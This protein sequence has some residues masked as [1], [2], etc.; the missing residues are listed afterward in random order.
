MSSRN[1]YGGGNRQNSQLPNRRTANNG[2]RSQYPSQQGQY[3]NQQGQQGQYGNQAAQNGTRQAQ[4]AQQAQYGQQNGQY[5]QQAQYGQQ[6]G[7]YAQ[8][9]QYGQQNGQYAQ[10]ATQTQNTVRPISMPDSRSGAGRHASA[11]A[12]NANA[13]GNSGAYS[14]DN[15]VRVRKK[16]SK[17]RTLK[18]VLLVILI[19][20]LVA[21]AAVAAYG[22][23]YKSTIESNI[24]MDA[25]E[26]QQL[27]E[28]LAPVD[29]NK[30]Q[31][32][33]VL[34]VGS[35]NWETYG[36]RSDAL[37]LVRIDQADHKVTMVSIP[38]DTPYMLNGQKVKINQAFSEQGATGAVKA[39][40]ELTG[41]SISYYAEIEFAGLANFVDQIGGIYVNV[42]YTIDYQ[43]YTNDQAT[44][45]IE[46]GQQR[47]SGEQCVALARM[48]TAYGDDQDA[49]RQ[50]NVRAMTEALLKT[51][52]KSSPAAIPGLIQN[53]TQCFST[54]M[55]LN[56]MVNLALDFAQADNVQIYT[57]TGPYK[58]DIDQ[59][60]GM[61]LCYEDPEGWKTL[62][63][64]VDKGEDPQN[65]TTT[66]NGK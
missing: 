3:G 8:Q 43:V 62:M 58:G 1:E 13:Y 29:E 57:C 48:R 23:W 42:P 10:Q 9:A 38:R 21:V 11:N 50:S 30:A 36:E 4:Y 34:L 12:A 51:V 47:L 66:V 65:S 37:I 33:Y 39:V 20:L 6:N 16:R 15:L 56:T 14:H 28:V 5:A 44:V 35:D 53:L 60:T 59:A 49:K 32:F 55:D 54:S 46:A 41:V 45:H 25:Q 61:W 19:V 2:Q 17:H 7:Q 27:Q 31:P 63:E 40:E 64:K 18:R 24:A 22:L 26:Q 52:L